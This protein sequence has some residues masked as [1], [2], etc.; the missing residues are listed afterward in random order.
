MST[1]IYNG[2]KFNSTDWK[3]VLEQLR[4]IK[5]EAVEQSLNRLT[6]G[7]TQFII[8]NKLL[9]K[10]Y[11]EIYTELKSALRNPVRSS[12]LPG[13]NFS[14][15]LYPTREGDIYGYYFDGLSTHSKLL[16]QFVTEY[17]YYDNTDH[18]DDI[19]YVDWCARGDKWDELVTHTFAEA[20]FLYNI[21]SEID[22]DKSNILY[23]IR[24]LIEP[25][26]LRESRDNKINTVIDDN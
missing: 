3:E 9:D 20:G 25:L 7:L 11:Y 14:V 24:L 5:E 4:S 13:F 18:P 10:D 22:L 15:I 16:D 17:A 2:I 21:V 12:F 6:A 1:K 26:R 8:G 23:D 19:D